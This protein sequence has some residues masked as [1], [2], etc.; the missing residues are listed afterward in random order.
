MFNMQIYRLEIASVCT[1][2]AP[3]IYFSVWKDRRNWLFISLTYKKYT[4]QGE[5]IPK[6]CTLV[7]LK[8][9]NFENSAWM[10]VYISSKLKDFSPIAS[11]NT[12]SVD[13]NTYDTHAIC[14]VYGEFIPLHLSLL[15]LY[16][17]HDQVLIL[18]IAESINRL[19]QWTLSL[20]HQLDS[21][22]YLTEA[23]T[24]RHSN[25]LHGLTPSNS[26]FCPFQ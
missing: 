15:L 24:L 19:G 1:E 26:H 21:R 7:S 11:N 5:N 12:S 20:N 14:N 18:P 17:A 8:F 16:K 2:C 9:L 13:W 6:R 10:L 3:L 23:T 25:E 22:L 4:L